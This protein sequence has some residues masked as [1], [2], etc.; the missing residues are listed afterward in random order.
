MHTSVRGI[1][2]IE[3]KIVLIHRIK[4]KDNMYREYYVI[5]GGKME[6]NETEEETLLREIREELGI[7][8]NPI[9]KILRYKSDYDDSVQ[10]FYECEYISGKIGTGNGP[11]MRE[12]RDEKELFEVVEIEREKIESI[13]LV[14]EEIKEIVKW[15]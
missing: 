2:E 8:V 14:P 7:V 3:G 13:N 4:K 5:P 1:I 12:K 15:R 11:E 9:K 10:N 6:K